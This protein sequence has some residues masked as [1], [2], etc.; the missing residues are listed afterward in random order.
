MRV[1]ALILCLTAFGCGEES[2]EPP[3][4][5]DL[6][7]H[8][9]DFAVPTD[10]GLDQ[11]VPDLGRDDLARSHPDLSMPDLGANDRG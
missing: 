7:K 6:Y 1:L 4:Q 8:P 10:G 5:P 11:G 9:Y 2:F 3:A